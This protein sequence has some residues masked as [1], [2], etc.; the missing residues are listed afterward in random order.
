MSDVT[1]CL[2][3]ETGAT[4]T[5]SVFGMNR[6][7]RAVKDWPQLAHRSRFRAAALAKDCGISLRQLERFFLLRTSKPPQRWLNE[8]RQQHAI[9]L[10]VEGKPVK[11]VAYELGYKQPSH[12]SREFK[13]F[14]GVSPN[15]ARTREFPTRGTMSPLVLECCPE[16][17][18]PVPISAHAAA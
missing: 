1:L 12:F 18:N 17:S 9:V 5:G 3:I 8:L 16:V 14:H 10:I 7:L 15:F 4:Q 2:D 13:R 11:E 6:R